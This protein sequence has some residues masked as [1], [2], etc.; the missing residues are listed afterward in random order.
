[1][2]YTDPVPFGP[3]TPSYAF[4]PSIRGEPLFYDH[5]KADEMGQ[6]RRWVLSALGIRSIRPRIRLA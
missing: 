3:N 4:G 1:M 6:T 2:R 5:W